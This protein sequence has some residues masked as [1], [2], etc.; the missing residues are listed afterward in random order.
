VVPEGVYPSVRRS[1]RER[2]SESIS[3]SQRTKDTRVFRFQ[4]LTMSPSPDELK[5]PQTCGNLQRQDVVSVVA[6][7]LN[8]D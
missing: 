7:A 6:I 2:E 3:R 4:Q 1:L 8:D 5:K